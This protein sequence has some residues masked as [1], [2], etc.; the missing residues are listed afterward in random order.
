MAIPVDRPNGPLHKL[1]WSDFVRF[2]HVSCLV[3]ASK[4]IRI[5][6]R[7]SSHRQSIQCLLIEQKASFAKSRFDYQMSIGVDPASIPEIR[8]AFL[9]NINQTLLEF[10][11]DAQAGCTKYH[12]SFTSGK[13]LNVARKWLEENWA[14]SKAAVIEDWGS[15]GWSVREG[16]FHVPVARQERL[17]I[18]NT[19]GHCT[20]SHSLPV[21]A[22]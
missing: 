19:L 6:A 22:S 14:V 8:Q 16:V 11:M 4:A 5:A 9:H 15:L 3:D 12:S 18:S 17:V 10:E 20:Y 2:L 21:V 1:H 13:G 7:T